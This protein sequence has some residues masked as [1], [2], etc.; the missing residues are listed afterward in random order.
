MACAPTRP[1]LTH[2][3]V[4]EKPE[5]HTGEEKAYKV[6][7]HLVETHGF[8]QFSCLPSLT[9]TFYLRCFNYFFRKNHDNLLQTPLVPERT[10]VLFMSH[11][12]ESVLK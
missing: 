4:E 12:P 5:G 2:H 11:L 3:K 10:I 9:S 6:D 7:I 8:V 1:A